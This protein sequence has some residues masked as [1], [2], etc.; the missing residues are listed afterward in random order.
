M[1]DRVAPFSETVLCELLAYRNDP[2]GYVT[3]VFQDLADSSYIMAVRMPNWDLPFI[4]IGSRGFMKYIEVVAG[5]DT[6]WNRDT[7]Q[8]EA[9]RYDGSYIVDWVPFRGNTKTG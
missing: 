5:Q 8:Q 9:Y 3:Y 6:W 4:E 2:E 1:A 7:G